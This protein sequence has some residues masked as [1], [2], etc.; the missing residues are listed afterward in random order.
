[1][2]EV[3]LSFYLTARYAVQDRTMFKKIVKIRNNFNPEMYYIKMTLKTNQKTAE[4][5]CLC[6]TSADFI[7]SILI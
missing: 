5:M 1:M 6:T 7:F 2:P 3:S 4:A